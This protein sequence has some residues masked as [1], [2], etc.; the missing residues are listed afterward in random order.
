MATY[1]IDTAAT[2][3]R[4]E[5]AGF[6]TDQAR[7]ITASIVE[8]DADNATKTDLR[9]IEQQ[10]QTGFAR[11]ETAIAQASSQTQI[12]TIGAALGAVAIAT[13]ILIAALG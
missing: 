7:E 4:L 13:A 3:A 5:R 12:R 2:T 11:L 8:A 1:S 6:T 9:V 10:I